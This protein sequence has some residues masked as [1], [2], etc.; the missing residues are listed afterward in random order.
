MTLRVSFTAA[1]LLTRIQL[2]GDYPIE[3]AGDPDSYMTSGTL[4]NFMGTALAHSWEL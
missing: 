2:L 1:Q 3:Q 4:Y